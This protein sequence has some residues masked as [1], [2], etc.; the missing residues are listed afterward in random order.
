MTYSAPHIRILLPLL[1][2]VAALLP[3]GAMAQEATEAIETVEVEDKIVVAKDMAEAED[4]VMTVVTAP[5]YTMDG[6]KEFNPDPTRAVWMSALFPGLGQI[7]NRRYWKLPIITAGF[8][9]LGY[10][11]SWNARMHSDYSTAYADL[12]DDDPDT[13]SYMDFF[14]PTVDESSLGKPLKVAKTIIDATATSAL[15]AAS[16]SISSVWSTHTSTPLSLISTSLLISPWMW[17]RRSSPRR[18]AA[19]LL[20]PSPGP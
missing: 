14:P 5:G 20:R 8:M 6:R 7:Y 1:L 13:K 19:N 18:A 3:V 11:T 2:L 17:P 9:G 15:Y 4:S 16:V 12:M 10:G